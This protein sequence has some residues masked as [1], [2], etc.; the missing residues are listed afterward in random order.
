MENNW[1]NKN[2][3]EALKNSLNGL[4]YSVK[5]QKNLK[6][7]LIIAILVII[8]SVVLK[9]SKIEMIF[10]CISVCFVIFAEVVN[11]AVEKTVDLITQ[12]YNENAKIAKDVAAGAVIIS[13]INSI[14]VGL[15]IFGDKIINVIK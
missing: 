9:I 3:L 12:K 5:T 11:T 8:I 1:K 2:F 6:I 10:I 14:I 13:A 7:Q 4:F 15:I